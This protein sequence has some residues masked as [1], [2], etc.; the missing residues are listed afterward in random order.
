ML[1]GL[2]PEEAPAGSHLQAN[3]LIYKGLVMNLQDI[4]RQK[5][6][7]VYSIRPDAT[8]DDV[9]QTLVR[10]NVGSLVVRDG[11]SSS[12]MLGIITERDIL[13]ACAAIRSSLGQM[14]V[15]DA[16]TE[17]VA[18]GTPSD[19]VEDTMGTMT[20]RRIRHLPVLDE[21]GRLVGLVSIGDIVKA[22]HDHLTLENHYLKTYIHGEVDSLTDSAIYARPR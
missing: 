12:P 13:K 11:D 16:M 18:T 4:L 3:H 21:D 9:V 15:R 8:L 19:S 10:Y 2:N 22:Q 5:G 20:N 1:K 7:T 14:H 6:S 17:H